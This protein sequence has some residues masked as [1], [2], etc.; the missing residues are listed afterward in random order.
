VGWSGAWI[1]GGGTDSGSTG[2]NLVLGSTEVNLETRNTE[3]GLDHGFIGTDL[4]PGV[5]GPRLE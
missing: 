3:E 4:V 2:V 1:H 5:A